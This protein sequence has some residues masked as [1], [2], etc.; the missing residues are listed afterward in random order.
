V[1]VI[2]YTTRTGLQIGC[3]YDRPAPVYPISHDMQRLQNSLL[4]TPRVAPLRTWVGRAL[5]IALYL[6]TVLIVA[7]SLVTLGIVL[8]R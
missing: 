6:L 2:P 4:G 5:D 8:L 1:K 7:L 3:R